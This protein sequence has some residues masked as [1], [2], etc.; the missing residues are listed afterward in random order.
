MNCR[1]AE[2]QIFAARDGALDEFRRAALA[3]HLDDCAA[4][5][6]VQNDLSTFVETWRE[7][8]EQVRVPDPQ[9]E[10]RKLQ[11]RIAE[12]AQPRRSR[13][14]WLALPSAAFAAA[15][16]AIGVHLRP[17]ST[18]AIPT[19]K[20]A[21]VGVAA[22]PPSVATPSITVSTAI[23]AAPAVV[24]VDDKSGWTFVWDGDS[25]QHI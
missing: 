15:A 1:E 13:A 2:Q 9:I 23:N 18:P 19:S 7:G 10:W 4:C 6:R 5:R 21:P 17:T 3:S 16:L 12:P 8:S 20:P 25:G 24:F 11:R 14:T 22:V